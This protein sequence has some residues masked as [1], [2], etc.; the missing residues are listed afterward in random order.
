MIGAPRRR[1]VL[2]AASYRWKDRE[3]T[4]AG[5]KTP[6][7]PEEAVSETLLDNGDRPDSRSRLCLPCPER[8]SSDQN[9]HE[10]PEG[11]GRNQQPELLFFDLSE[12]VH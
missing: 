11:T 9:R 2:R 5:K 1:G 6:S 10:L 12:P 7:K 3:E 8:F 4:V